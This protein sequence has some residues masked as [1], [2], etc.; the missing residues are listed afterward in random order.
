MDINKLFLEKYKKLF[1]NKNIIKEKEGSLNKV[2]LSLIINKHSKILQIGEIEE[3]L[4]NFILSIVDKKYYIII[5][6]SDFDFMNFQNQYD[7]K[8][9]TFVIGDTRNV[10]KLFDIYY[11]LYEQIK[12]IFIYYKNSVRRFND[13]IRIKL[14]DNQYKTIGYKVIKK[15]IYINNSANFKNKFLESEVFLKGNEN[16]LKKAL[17]IDNEKI[18]LDRTSIINYFI[19]KYNL[20]NYLEIGVRDGTNFNKIKINSK[21]GVDPEPTNE[22]LGK[23]RIMTSDEYFLKI[24]D[25]AVKFD[26]IFI[27]GLHLDYQVDLDLKNSLKHLSQNG[28]IIM[29]DCNPP[30]KF[31][32]RENYELKNQKTPYWN[33]TVWKSYVKLRMNNPNLNMCV[34]DCD[35]GIGIIQ[36]GKQKTIKNIKNLRYKDLKSDREKILNLI[37]IYEFLSIF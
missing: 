6:N 2:L 31:H 33:G 32:Q 37:S 1:V 36:K 27:D 7:F 15:D 11:I 8:F 19:S 22:C 5:E 3:K 9:N 4:K 18:I 14:I 25:T 29:H 24:K 16:G 34:V 10:D 12:S 23:I 21:V 13:I 17:N 20:S 28:F 35:W 30:T 26:I